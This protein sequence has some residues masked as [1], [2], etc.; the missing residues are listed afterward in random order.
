MRDLQ[1]T[2]LFGSLGPV[3]G[4]DDDPTGFLYV[5]DAVALLWEI[6]QAFPEMLA[7]AAS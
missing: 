2:R 5:G 4:H 6:E 3:S 1:G 7:E